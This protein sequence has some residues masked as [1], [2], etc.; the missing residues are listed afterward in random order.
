M[1][2]IESIKTNIENLINNIKYDY[3]EQLYET[4]HIRRTE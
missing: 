2:N 3:L 1:G 4:M